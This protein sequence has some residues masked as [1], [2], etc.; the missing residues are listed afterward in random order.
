ML[1]LGSGAQAQDGAEC[2]SKYT[3]TN[4]C[5]Y[6]REAQAKFSSILPMQMSQTVTVVSA[7]AM[8][9]MLMI[10]ARWEMSKAD[11]DRR[12]VANGVS[13]AQLG[14]SMLALATNNACGSPQL[15]AF[16]RLGGKIRWAYNTAD[17]FPIT[18]P[19]VE[20]CPQP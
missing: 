11:L 12:L 5:A 1:S 16:V 15:A 4:V 13:P 2:F 8:G 3:K 17:H 7:A 14:E 20:S 6:A 9:P 10:T 18:S 19:T